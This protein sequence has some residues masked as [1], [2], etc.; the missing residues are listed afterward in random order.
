VERQVAHVWGA[1]VLAT[2]SVFVVEILLKL[3]VLTLSPILSI[4]AGMTFLVKAGMLSG[5]FYISA[6]CL[7]LTAVPM[8]LFP[9]YGPF[10]FGVVSAL[11]FFIPGLKYHRQ[12]LHSLRAKAEL[13]EG[14]N[15][16]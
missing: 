13:A 9:N 3:E 1:A 11:C 7:Y 16:P 5:S 4:I 8:A 2:M 15:K 6:A 10:M 12:R 14:R